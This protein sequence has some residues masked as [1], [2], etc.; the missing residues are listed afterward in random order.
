MPFPLIGNANYYFNNGEIRHEEELASSLSVSSFLHDTRRTLYLSIHSIPSLFYVHRKLPI[1]NRLRT[2]HSM[3]CQQLISFI[4]PISFFIAS[5][6][7]TSFF[8]IA[9]FVDGSL[10]LISCVRALT[11]N[12][13]DALCS[14]SGYW[15]PSFT[16]Y[17]RGELKSLLLLKYELCT[18]NL[19]SSTFPLSLIFRPWSQIDTHFYTSCRAP[20]DENIFPCSA[21]LMIAWFGQPSR[22]HCY[23]YQRIMLL[24]LFMGGE[25]QCHQN[26]YIFRLPLL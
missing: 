15:R 8:R 18:I 13:C 11:V 21:H 4:A 25:I 26:W 2:C 22:T 6:Q 20:V 9:F 12:L 23:S 10:L 14:R 24:T 19:N 5:N 7:F 17:F 1:E 16:V 3:S